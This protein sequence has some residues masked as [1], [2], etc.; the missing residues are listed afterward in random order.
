MTAT[1]QRHAVGSPQ[2]ASALPETGRIAIHVSAPRRGLDTLGGR[3]CYVC[4]RPSWAWFCDD[5][6]DMHALAEGV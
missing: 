4:Q 5:C 2:P 1:G 6:Y 3:R